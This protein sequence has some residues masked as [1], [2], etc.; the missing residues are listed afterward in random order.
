MYLTG[1][2]FVCRYFADTLAHNENGLS[3]NHSSRAESTT[4]QQTAPSTR[5][6]SPITQTN[7]NVTNVCDSGATSV[8]QNNSYKDPQSYGLP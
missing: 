8:P 2:I 7:N 4:N 6:P 5:L 3:T 1:K